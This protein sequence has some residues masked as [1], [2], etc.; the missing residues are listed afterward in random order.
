MGGIKKVEGGDR[1]VEE[2]GRSRGKS[3]EDK[4]DI[5]LCEIMRSSFYWSGQLIDYPRAAQT[6][7]G[8]VV[9]NGEVK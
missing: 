8:M 5:L 3:I 4:V 2:S 6:T 1:Q 7:G 9:G